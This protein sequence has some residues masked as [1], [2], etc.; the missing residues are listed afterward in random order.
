MNLF[1]KQSTMKDICFIHKVILLA[2]AILVISACDKQ[3]TNVTYDIRGNWT[4]TSFDDY[5]A[6]EVI[7]KT[8]S[9][10][11]NQFNNGDITCSFINNDLI[12]GFITGIKVT[13]TFS[14]NYTIGSNGEIKISNLLQTEINEPEWGRLFDSIVK[15][16][17]YE[18]RNNQLKIF[19]NQRKKSITFERVNK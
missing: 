17:S 3:E 16:E 14:G 4:V 8:N 13:N 18:V 6:F 15:A 19:Y 1:D 9:N 10:T 12:S 5:E 7:T 11:W 2:V